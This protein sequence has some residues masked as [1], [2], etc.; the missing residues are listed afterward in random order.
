MCYVICF[1]DVLVFFWLGLECRFLGFR[2]DCWWFG[3]CVFIGVL[4]FVVLYPCFFGTLVD[5]VF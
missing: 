1:Y 2:G 3:V 4:V 5:V